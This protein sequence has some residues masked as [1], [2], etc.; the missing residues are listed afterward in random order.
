MVVLGPGLH[1][2]YSGMELFRS[3]LYIILEV[4]AH[5]VEYVYKNLP[6]G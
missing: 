3:F 5:H 4:F 2:F 6:L 1:N